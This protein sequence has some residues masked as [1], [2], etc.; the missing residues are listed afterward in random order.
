VHGRLRQENSRGTSCILEEGLFYCMCQENSRRGKAAINV[1]KR[2]WV[3]RMISKNLTKMGSSGP[4]L[5][6]LKVF[7]FFRG[8][9]HLQVYNYIE[10]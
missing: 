7:K 4:K 2:D 3:T 6:A 1:L 5:V 9:F 10:I 8:A